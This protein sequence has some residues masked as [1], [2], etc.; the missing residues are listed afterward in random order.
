MFLATTNSLSGAGSTETCRW[1]MNTEDY[2]RNA[3][4]SDIEDKLDVADSQ[5]MKTDKRYSHEEMFAKIR[6]S[7][8]AKADA[9]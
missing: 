8:Y 4:N 5:A 9:R 6:E 3:D 1:V 7:I 2:Q